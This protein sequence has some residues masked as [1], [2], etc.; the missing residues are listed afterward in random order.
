MNAAMATRKMKERDAFSDREAARMLG[1]PV[2]KLYRIC[3]VFDGLIPMIN[4]S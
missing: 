2:S 3:D 4:G 1:I